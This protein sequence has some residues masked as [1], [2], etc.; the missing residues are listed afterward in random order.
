DDR[1]AALAATAPPPPA[2]RLRGWDCIELWVGNA[3]TTAGFLMGTLGFTCT[4]YAG[5][6][7][8]VRDKVSYVLEQGDVRL[9][10]TGALDPGSPTARLVLEHGD[11]VH[12]LAWVVDDARAAFEAAV[13][14]GARPVR[15]PWTET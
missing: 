15:E 10:V 8:G 5:P 13:D 7:T 1:H 12:D 2:T 3:R 6:E 14:R 4:G 11:G 9:V